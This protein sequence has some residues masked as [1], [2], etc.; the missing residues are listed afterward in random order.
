M[1]DAVRK[2]DPVGG[3]ATLAES[4]KLS[5]IHAMLPQIER[6]YDAH[7]INRVLNHPEVI[8]WVREYQIGKLDVTPLIANQANVLLMGE[9]GGLFFHQL[10]SGIYEVHTA[11]LPEGRGKWAAR[12]ARACLHVMFCQ[13]DALE[14]LTRVP[15]GNLGARAL[16]R[17]CG[18][19][20]EFTRPAELRGWVYRQDPISADVFSLTIQKWMRTAPALVE[21]G[22]WFHAKLEQ[23]YRKFGKVEKPHADDLIHDRYVGAAVEMLFANNIVKGLSFYNRWASVAGYQTVSINSTNPLTIDIGEALLCFKNADFW[24]MSCR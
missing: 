7:N 4:A 3:L 1:G 22:Q 13:A 12:M 14:I 5:E 19:D 20:Y 18:F 21:R 15:K 23:E 17:M 11:I 10:Q 2:I 16:T 8:E 6:Q 9:Y 24:V